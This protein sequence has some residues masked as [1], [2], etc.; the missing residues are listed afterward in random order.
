VAD[1]HDWL[2]PL[3]DAVVDHALRTGRFETVNRQEATSPPGHGIHV[4]VWPGPGK[5][6]RHSGLAVT[7]IVQ[8]IMIRLKCP[9]LAESR[10][11]V[12]PTIVAALSQLLGAYQTDLTL[13]DLCRQVDV[14]GAYWPQGLRWEPGWL[15]RTQRVY[16]IWL[17][18]VVDDLW[19]QEV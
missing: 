7:S 6:I 9:A 3:V 14:M 2:T 10:D 13:G 11:E 15:S 8:V 4:E 18:L 19:P 1:E 5:P 12:D 16:T 17:P